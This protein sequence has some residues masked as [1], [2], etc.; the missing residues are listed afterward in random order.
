MVTGLSGE[1]HS[2][3][4]HPSSPLPTLPPP[5]PQ[6]GPAGLCRGTC[7]AFRSSACGGGGGNTAF[8]WCPARG[9][10][11]PPSAQPLSLRQFPDP[12]HPRTHTARPRPQAK[13]VGP[14]RCGRAPG[15]P[16]RSHLPPAPADHPPSPGLG[17]V[18]PGRPRPALDA[19]SAPSPPPRWSGR[20]SSFEALVLSTAVR[21]RPRVLTQGPVGSRG[22]P[23]RALTQALQP[24]IQ[25]P[26]HLLL[27]TLRLPPLHCPPGP[28]LPWPGSC[29]T[30]GLLR[31]SSSMKP[32]QSAPPA[33]PGQADPECPSRD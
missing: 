15:P 32:S 25:G 5:L 19:S 8:P 27:P 26:F 21:P 10:R 24:G 14:T 11:P 6:P 2:H 23:P 22:H 3:P 18:V 20:H 30:H 4:L 31:S 17:W 1:A 13:P 12:A 7:V 33:S 9:Q 16:Q 28:L 29:W